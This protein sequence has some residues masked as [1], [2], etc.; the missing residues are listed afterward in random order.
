VYVVED[1]LSERGIAA[2]ELIDGMD[3]VPRRNLAKLFAE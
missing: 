1:A 3:L 2:N